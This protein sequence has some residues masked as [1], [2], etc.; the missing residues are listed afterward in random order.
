MESSQVTLWCLKPGKLTRRF[1]VPRRKAR[2]NRFIQLLALGALVV[3]L[4]NC[5]GGN[6]S[7]SG[8]SGPDFAISVT[9]NTVTIPPSGT[10]LTQ[11]SVKAKNGFTG[12]VTIDVSGLPPGTTLSPLSPF[13]IPSGSQNL[14]ITVPANAAQGNFIVTLH[15]TSGS[16][17]HSASVALQVQ[18]FA[19]FSV[20]LNNGSLSLSQGGS[21]N[22][23]VG[24]S[25]TSN[26][27]TDYR[28][29]FSVTGLPGGVSATFG[30]NPF[31]AGQ[32]ATL[33]TFSASTTSSLAN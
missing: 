25:L 10:L 19:S 20:V 26:G 29:Q 12:A 28:V 27:N 22:T 30:E 31:G 6:S 1:W 15:A 16:L 9:P 18:S 21:A 3:V 4:S 13:T 33:L 2:L 7:N 11:V 8:G 17:Q 14:S 24:L 32:P 23:I 5:G